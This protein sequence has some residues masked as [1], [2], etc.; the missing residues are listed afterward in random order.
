MMYAAAVYAATPTAT[1]T[2]QQLLLQRPPLQ[3]NNSRCCYA[4]RSYKTS[5]AAATPTVTTQRQPLLLRQTV[6]TWRRDGSHLLALEQDALVAA[7]PLHVPQR[8]LLLV[9][10]RH[11][12]LVVH[13]RQ[14][15]VGVPQVVTQ[16]LRR[17]GGGA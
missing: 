1:T 4:H 17:D 16:P 6:A 8:H 11:P 15:A 7:L 12:V 13:G 14:Q 5:T 10:A 3:H 9:A 2:Q